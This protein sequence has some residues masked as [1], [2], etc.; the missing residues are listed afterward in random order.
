ML[1]SAKDN[2]TVSATR[3]N[4]VSSRS[5]MIMLFRIKQTE[6]GS[7]TISTINFADL[8]GSE[9]T[10]KTKATG[11]RLKEAQKINL[12]LTQLGIVIGQLVSGK[13]VAY[14]DSKLTEVLQD[15]LGGNCKTTLVINCSKS[16]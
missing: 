3:M 6:E 1:E 13:H 14:R 4:G 11:Q 10:T 8:A 15:S 16:L 5:H 2:R 12:S 7:E 9:K